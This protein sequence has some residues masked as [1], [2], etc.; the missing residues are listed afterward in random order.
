MLTY[1]PP[2]PPA[3]TVAPPV[4]GRAQPQTTTTTT[5]SFLAEENQLNQ[6]PWRQSSLETGA[7]ADIPQIESDPIV[8]RSLEGAA[9]LPQIA[10]SLAAQ[11]QQ[12]SVEGIV[13]P[14]PHSGSDP[15][16]QNSLENVSGQRSLEGV[17]HTPVL[18]ADPV[19]QRSLEV[20][21]LRDLATKPP[22]GI[23]S[24]G[25]NQ[26]HMS[27]SS[28]DDLGIEAEVSWKRGKGECRR[29]G[30]RVVYN[31][32]VHV[33]ITYCIAPNFE[34]EVYKYRERGKSENGGYIHVLLYSG[35]CRGHKSFGFSED[36]SPNLKILNPRKFGAIRYSVVN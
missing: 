20:L 7:G 23:G 29:N 36:C 10:S 31:V 15:V 21:E 1:S 8:Q 16:G 18:E 22:P 5:L 26:W 25:L 9:Q 35:K 24:G 13:Q 12:Q 28:D 17:M 14:P 4:V 2:G 6:V 30:G 11:Q 19:V 32:H 27:D 3:A 34:A 33:H